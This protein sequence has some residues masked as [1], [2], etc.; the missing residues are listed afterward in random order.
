MK[1][2]L[3]FFSFLSFLLGFSQISGNSDLLT[4]SSHSKTIKKTVDSQNIK[5]NI[6]PLS[7][8]ILSDSIVENSGLIYFNNLLWTHND[9]H[10]TTLYGLDLKGKITKKIL[11]ENVENT[12]WEEISQDETHIYI[13]DFGNNYRGNRKDLHILK[14]EK[15]QLF[16]AKPKIERIN[17][18][19]SNQTDFNVQKRNEID[20]DCEAFLVSKDSIYLFTKQWKS[21]NTGVY[22]LPK[23]AGNYIA[24]LKSTLN[25][26]G[27]ITGASLFASGE[28]IALCGY[29]K[30]FTTFL[31]IISDIK[32][33]DFTNAKTQK[34]KL[35]LP[36]H[37]IEGITN[38][39]DFN[40]YL[41]SESFSKKP[42]FR[43]KQKL[44]LINLK[45]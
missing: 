1:K 29:T 30:K 6:K 35:K 43:N 27:L 18:S 23:V 37:Q 16:N 11:L 10:D 25:C 12:D 40:F 5:K 31:Y 4:E 39:D 15:N 45:P 7:S 13:G 42:F 33:N 44:H 21:K 19:Y 41:S 14:I 36:F 34:V 26:K 38:F 20:F 28:K 3:V 22:V 8:K 9:D 17:F 32:S 2:I 24:K